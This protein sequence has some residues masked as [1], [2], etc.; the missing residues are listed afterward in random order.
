MREMTSAERIRA[1]LNDEDVDRV[2]FSPFLAYVWEQF[3][4]DL[5]SR[6]QA[7]FL[8][9]VGADP[10]WRG[11]P[12]PVRA[13][14]PQVDVRR[15]ERGR[16]TVSETE[17][18]VGT[19]RTVHR[20]SDEGNTSFLL[21]HPLKA[22]EDYKVLTWIEQ[23]TR[24]VYDATDVEA[25]LANDG[26]SGVSFGMLVPRGKSAYQSLVEHYAG[27]EELVYA[28]ADFPEVVEELVQTMVANDLAAVRLAAQAPYEYFITWED[29]STQNYSPAQYDAY[30]GPEI[31][32]WCAT[33]RAHDKRYIQHACGHVRDL[34]GRM[35]S[36]GVYGIESVSS[37]PTG[38]IGL[39]ETRAVV[40]DRVAIVGGI[41]PT[42]FLRL[43]LA[44]LGPYVER[45]IADGSGGPFVLANSDS[46]PPGVT[47]EK[48]RRVADVARAYR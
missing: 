16:D 26:C 45:V 12:C 13:I 27:T 34:V 9:D 42:A 20:R 8:A 22:P 4:E 36:H 46:C 7:K 28:L 23:R 11:A 3:P 10:L 35:R 25:H 39:R 18:P 40:G 31:G 44:E 14:G 38:N 32:Q 29:S 37:P 24:F 41:E 2:P 21:E 15:V 6:G 5:R 17:T 48:F 47:V 30:I 19:L 43:S 1:A 33:L